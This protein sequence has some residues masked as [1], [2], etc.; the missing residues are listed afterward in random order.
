MT[1]R[2]YMPKSKTAEW[3]TPNWLFQQLDREFNFTVDAAATTENNKVIHFWNKEENGLKKS[4]PGKVVW[5]NPPWSAKDLQAWTEKAWKESSLNGV[6][7]V[8]LVPAK[9]DQKWWHL[10]ALQ[11]ERRFIPG[12]VKFS[13]EDNTYPGP[14]VV[15]V[16]GPDVVPCGKTL[17]RSDR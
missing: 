3:E 6:T 8:M 16:F 1:D 7:I 9:T 14:V 5:I 17:I 2:A 15:L 4:W 10:Y 13:D 12:R 11:A